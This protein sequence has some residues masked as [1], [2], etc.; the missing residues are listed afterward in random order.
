MANPKIFSRSP[1]EGPGF[2][3]AGEPRPNKVQVVG[4]INENYVTGGIVVSPHQ[5]GLT[6]IDYI[7][8]SVVST[9][10]AGNVPTAA[11]TPLAMYIYATNKV[12][13]V[14]DS[15]T[16]AGAEATNDENVVLR[17][18]AQGESAFA[19]ERLP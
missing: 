4:E 16:D 15:G 17:F 14:T 13:V 2:N 10:D 5:L 3:A 8:F 6:T 12:L 7:S 11:A 19:P 1:L 9:A 18:V